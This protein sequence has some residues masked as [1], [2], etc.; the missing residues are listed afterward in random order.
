MLTCG[1]FAALFPRAS[2]QTIDEARRTPYPLLLQESTDLPDIGG[3]GSG[4]GCSAVVSLGPNLSPAV[5]DSDPG[6]GPEVDSDPGDGPESSDSV[7]SGRLASGMPS[8]SSGRWVAGVGASAD[9]EVSGTGVSGRRGAGVGFCGPGLSGTED[10]AG[11]PEAGSVFAA[12]AESNG[13]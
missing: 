12:I 3:A 7:E 11:A 1:I 9:S 10:M 2:Q 8:G 4:V 5:F 6:D 13:S